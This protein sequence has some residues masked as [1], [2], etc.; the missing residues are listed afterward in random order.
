MKKSIRMLVGIISHPFKILIF[1]LNG[2][3]SQYDGLKKR[4]IQREENKAVFR[5]IHM[6][7][8]THTKI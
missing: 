8:L 4:A 6:A 1:H 3:M 7:S 5:S 2:G